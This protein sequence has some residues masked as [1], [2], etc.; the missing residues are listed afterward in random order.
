MNATRKRPFCQR[1]IDIALAD[2]ANDAGRPVPQVVVA[3]DSLALTSAPSYDL[4][5]RNPHGR[6]RL[7]VSDRERFA[8]GLYGRAYLYSR[9]TDILP[10]PG[11]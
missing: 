8:R 11:A 7:A 5:I 2:L 1:A 3:G 4:V 9:F 10:R 6:L